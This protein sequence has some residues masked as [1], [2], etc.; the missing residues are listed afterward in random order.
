MTRHRLLPLQICV[1][2]AAA[3]VRLLAPG[4]LAVMM[5]L[6][7][8]LVP[9][10]LLAPLLVATLA[11]PRGRVGVPALAAF[12]LTDVALLVFAW[13]FPDSGD[14]PNEIAVPLA[15]LLRLG[16]ALGPHDRFIAGYD[17]TGGV[18]SLIGY[19]GLAAYAVCAIAT[20]ILVLRT[21]RTRHSA[22]AT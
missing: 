2:L 10:L 5:L 21:R 20:A 14:T 19:A 7:F 17:V 9:L 1:V 18:L 13:T 11:L 6:S 3:A 15:R 22:P 12:A 4:G 8:G 16:D